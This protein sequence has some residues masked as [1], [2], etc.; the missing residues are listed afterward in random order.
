M[1]LAK[2]QHKQAQLQMA[3]CTLFLLPLSLN[4]HTSQGLDSIV[5]YGQ[6]LQQTLA[7]LK[8]KNIINPEQ[9]QQF[10]KKSIAIAHK[11]V[12]VD[13]DLKTI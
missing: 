1:V 11:L 5:K 10:N 6:K 13:Q 8:L 7:K 3:S 4:Q 12:L 9:L 2:I